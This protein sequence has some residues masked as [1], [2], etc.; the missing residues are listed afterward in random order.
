VSA[1]A[2][3][4]K[5]TVARRFWKASLFASLAAFGK[6]S[7]IEQCTDR[8]GAIFDGYAVT[9]PGSIIANPGFFAVFGTVVTH[10]KISHDP[11]PVGPWGGIQ[12]GG[13]IIGMW[14][15]PFISDRFGRKIVMGL[16]SFMLL[17]VCLSC[18]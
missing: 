12:S 13:Q 17:L 15:S 16:L 5:K 18:S 10:G 9:V 1:Y 14:G 3:W 2:E 4:D 7:W 8:A 6:S 11:Q